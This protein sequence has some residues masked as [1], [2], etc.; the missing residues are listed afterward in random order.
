MRLFVT[1]GTGFIGTPLRR[2]LAG[3]ELLVVDP[4]RRPRSLR[5]TISAAISSKSSA[6]KSAVRDFEPAACLHLA[7]AGLPDYSLPTSL[8]NFQ[9]GLGLFQFLREIGCPR[10]VV[11]GTC[12]E[13][14][15][16]SGC[17]AEDRHPQTQ[18]LFA[19]FKAAQRLVATSL[20]AGSATTL[21]WARPFYV[22]GPGQRPASLI[23]SC[24]RSLQEGRKPEVKTPDLLND[25]IHVEDV[26]AG[27][28]VLAT[29]P[30]AA[31]IYNLGS[32][33]PTRIRDVVNLLARCLGRPPVFEPSVAAGAGFWADMTRMVQQTGWRPQL[34][35]EEGIRRTVDVWRA[36]P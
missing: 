23:P 5:A 17:L 36:A 28:A 16:L 32:G 2:A 24:Y 3:H 35:L 20:F 31:G 21:I 33:Q 8:K 34:S 22:Y 30:A 18:G 11:T 29:S 10:L 26:A 25:F 14:G 7:W 13:Y 6:W 9:A 1:G 4:R 15:D 19:A 12:F 27:L